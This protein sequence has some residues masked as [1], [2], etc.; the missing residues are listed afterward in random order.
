MKIQIMD[1][2]ITENLGFESLIQ[3]VKK[4]I[5]LFLFIFK[6]LLI[7]VFNHFWIS[8]FTYQKIVKIKNTQ[9]CVKNLK[10]IRKKDEKKIYLLEQKF[11]A[12]IFSNFPAQDLKVR[13]TGS[14]LAK[15]VK[16]SI[17]Y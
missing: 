17:L 11:E 3:K 7:F 8:C 5:V 4:I 14:N 15:E 2:K 16:I 6:K 13:V 9:F 10:I 12:Q 1:G